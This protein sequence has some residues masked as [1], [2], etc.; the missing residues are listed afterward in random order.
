MPG[1]VRQSEVKKDEVGV[2]GDGVFGRTA[3]GRLDYLVALRAEAGAQQPPDRRLVVDEQD[4]R[5]APL[6]QLTNMGGLATGPPSPPA[7]LGIANVN[8]KTTPPP[9]RL[10]ASIRPP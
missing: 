10:T 9:G 7:L 2:A 5:A 8:R 3:I 4:R 6:G 1:Y